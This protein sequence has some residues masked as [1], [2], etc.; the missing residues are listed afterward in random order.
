M[1]KLRNNVVKSLRDDLG[2]TTTGIVVAMFGAATSCSL[3]TGFGLGMT[4]SSMLGWYFRGGAHAR[5]K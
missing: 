1:A 5:W 2:R 3:L 4:F